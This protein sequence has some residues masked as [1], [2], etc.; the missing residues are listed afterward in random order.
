MTMTMPFYALAMFITFTHHFWSQL[1]EGSEG[2]RE[3]EG[4]GK[5]AEEEVADGDV[6]HENVSRRSH[7][8]KM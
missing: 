3:G 1:P 2:V 7:R 6:D 4:Y 8:L 5:S